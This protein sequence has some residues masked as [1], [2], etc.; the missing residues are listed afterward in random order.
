MTDVAAVEGMTA[1]EF[2]EMPVPARG[3]PW[4]LIDGELVVNDPSR[5]HG[6]VLG[7]L[8][9]ELESWVRAKPGR[10]EV[11]LPLDVQ[12]DERNVFA[13][14]LAWYAQ[15]R[16]PERDAAPPYPMPD[17]AVEARSPSTWR[18]DIG[19]KKSGYE[20]HGLAELWLLDTAAEVVLVFRRSQREAAAFDVALELGG[21]EELTSP[22]LPGFA[23]G[24]AT[25]FAP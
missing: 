8:Q 20:R 1:P 22:P 2:L 25:I 12:L 4:N 3:R 6:R 14:D 19:E 15:G 18:F 23:L 16:A 24:V 17:I 21:A 11:A 13:P 9:F 7:Q 5:L 10:G